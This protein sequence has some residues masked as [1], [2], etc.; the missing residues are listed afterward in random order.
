[1]S[2]VVTIE[3]EDMTPHGPY[4]NVL[5]SP[6]Y[7]MAFYANGDYAEKTCTLPQGCG[8]WQV[9]ITGCSNN[10]NAAGIVLYVDGKR[11]K[12][13]TFSG[14]A[15]VTQTADVVL[16]VVG[17]ESVV[18]LQLETDNGSSDTYIDRI[19]FTFQ[20]ASI[21]RPALVLPEKGAFYTDKYR[22][23]FVEAG[24]TEQQVSDR[25]NLL[26]QHFFYGDAS[27]KALYYPVGDD[28]AYILDVNNDDVRS[29]GQSY[30]MMICV[31]MDKQEEFNRLWKWAKNHQQHQLGERKGYFAW[32]V[33]KEGNIMDN[34]PASDGE[35]YFV[36]ALLFAANRWGNGTGIFDYAAEANAILDAC[37]NKPLPEY[38]YS[39][40]TNLFNADEQ[41][42]VFTPYASAAA[43]TDPSYHLPA[44]YKLWSM[45]ADSRRDFY[46]QMA[47]KSRQMFGKF[48]H[49][50]TGLMPDYANFD[51]TP[52]GE[53]GHNNFR[54]DAWRCIMNM[55]M[56]YAWFGE[57]E[58]ELE[59]V[60]RWHDFFISQGVKSYYSNYTLDGQQDSGNTDHSAG[61]VACNATGVLASTD[62]RAWDFIE[63]FW[64]PPLPTGKY[65]YYDGMLYFLNFLHTSGHFR[66]YKPQGSL[67]VRSP[68]ST[69]RVSVTVRD[70]KIF[71]GGNKAWHCTLT[72]MS[73]QTILSCHTTDGSVSYPAAAHGLCLLQLTADDGER[74]CY[75]VMLPSLHGVVD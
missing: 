21:D 42:V 33:G 44:F 56:D 35:E 59:L 24:Y 34:N 10:G 3:A 30:G 61:L 7:G 67:A 1:M 46:G 11:I 28:E 14:T 51:G 48:A 16:D 26:W 73:G 62:R 23:M 17:G 43:K 19:C 38:P 2:Q 12:D 57:D 6:Y 25:L 69:G 54:Y 36:M 22:N 40:V 29:E 41:Q 58:Q 70:G 53:G 71:I 55:A 60:K 20:S 74:H 72:S 9:G 32:Q 5:D 50:T 47:E 27:Q 13:F 15:T 49:A 66:I 65:R 52:N 39:S 4:A 45:W 37:N 18:K 64:N 75:K 31:Q 8:N 68:R 63:D